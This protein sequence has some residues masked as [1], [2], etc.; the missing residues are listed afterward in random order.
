M[1]ESFI[2]VMQMHTINAMKS[3]VNLAPCS[4][5][6]LDYNNHP[7]FGQV[8][9]NACATQAILSVLLNAEGLKDS[10]GS[11]L[12]EFRDFTADFPPGIIFFIDC[13]LFFKSTNMNRHPMINSMTLNISLL[14]HDLFQI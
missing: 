8:I 11:R 12:T 10:L 3:S 9:N 7:S 6:C 4:R 14:T 2:P 1:D 5:R 13:V